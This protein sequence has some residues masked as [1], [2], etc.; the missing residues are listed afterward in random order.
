MWFRLLILACPICF[1]PD[2]ANTV[3]GVRAA[4]AVLGAI[5]TV[6]LAGFAVFAGRLARHERAERQDRP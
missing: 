5:T 1:Q 2:D 4:V 6:V 3:M